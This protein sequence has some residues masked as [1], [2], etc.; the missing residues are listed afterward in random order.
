MGKEDLALLAQ[1]DRRGDAEA[2]REIVA[3]YVDLVFGTCRRV[4]GNDA[5]AEDVTQECFMRLA[6]DPRQVRRS[7]GGWLHTLATHRSLDFLRAQSRRRERE[8]RFA[9]EQPVTVAREWADI[10]DAVDE[11][12]ECLPS[13]QRH[14]IVA[15]FLQGK[16]QEAIATDLGVTRPAVSYHVREGVSNLRA[17]LQRRGVGLAAGALVAGAMTGMAD[18]APPD[19]AAKLGRL[20]LV[21]AKR[22]PVKTIPRANAWKAWLGGGALA[23][24]AV[25]AAMVWV[26]ARGETKHPVAVDTTPLPVAVENSDDDARP[27]TPGPEELYAIRPPERVRQTAVPMAPVPRGDTATTETGA[28]VLGIVVDGRDVP[29]EGAS[30]YLQTGPEQENP[31]R[32]APVAHTAKDGAFRVEGVAANLERIFA[33]HEDFSPGWRSI[34]VSQGQTNEVRITLIP[35]GTVEG[36]VTVAGLP[37]KSSVSAWRA[38]VIGAVSSGDDGAYRLT[39]VTPG[40]VEIGAFVTA[41]RNTTS[42]AIVEAGKV[43]RVDFDFPETSAAVEGHVAANG[44]PVSN[45]LVTIRIDGEDGLSEGYTAAADAEG[46]YHFENVPGGEASLAAYGGT[47]VGDARRKSARFMVADE[48]VTRHDMDLTPGPCAVSGQID[49][50]REE[51]ETILSILQGEVVLEEFTM[52]ALERLNGRI[53]DYAPVIGGVYRFAGLDVG[54]YTLL[55]LSMPSEADSTEDHLGEA[56]VAIEPVRLEDAAEATIDLWPSPVR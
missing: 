39:R 15:H 29:I 49:V 46:F 12:I 45:A 13:K 48:G 18:A 3:R 11:A 53:V 4:L 17:I 40:I 1:W 52:S 27:P 32:N 6:R 5:D 31:F 14:V 33:D 38:G 8:T 22:L 43:T 26:A 24:A 25:G 30:I 36:V 19:L 23:A 42:T 16:T 41:H 7:L 2:F 50:P 56:L 54:Q 21:G 28:I 37:C 34:D 20:A 35:G 9:E 44:A 10:Q 55:C 51:G 47:P